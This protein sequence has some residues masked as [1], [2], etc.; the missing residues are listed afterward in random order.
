MTLGQAMI[1][2]S[3][4][5]HGFGEATPAVASKTATHPIIGVIVER[6]G[7][8]S[9]D[10]NVYALRSFLPSVLKNFVPVA[11]LPDTYGQR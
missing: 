1:L 6:I 10:L 7:T 4:L 5:R 11:S 3:R 2:P 8:A 9:V